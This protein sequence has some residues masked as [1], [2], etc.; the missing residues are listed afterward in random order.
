MEKM[1]Q[2]EIK[3]SSSVLY[4]R[5]RQGQVSVAFV[6]HASLPADPIR[7][8]FAHKGNYLSP[9][10]DFVATCS[11]E[12]F[13]SEDKCVYCGTV[14]IF[15]AQ[16]CLYLVTKH[17]VLFKTSIQNTSTLNFYKTIKIFL[18]QPQNFAFACKLPP[19]FLL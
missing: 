12:Q 9:I 2:R 3:F 6:T 14:N 17:S 5:E 15:C 4:G 10:C 16:C 8:R 19:I 1:T 7:N 18:T 11:S 13:R